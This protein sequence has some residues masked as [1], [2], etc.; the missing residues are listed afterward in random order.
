MLPVDHSPRRYDLVAW[1][2]LKA[3][4][5]NDKAPVFQDGVRCVIFMKH[6]LHMA[7]EKHDSNMISG[8]VL[9]PSVQIILVW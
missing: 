6:V 2:L 9:V 8:I 5:R 4:M 3:P 1:R 7:K